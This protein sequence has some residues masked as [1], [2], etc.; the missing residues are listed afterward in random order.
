MKRFCRAFCPKDT[1]DLK[2]IHMKKLHSLAFYALVTPVITLSSGVLFA[3]QPVD[4]D[5]APQQRSS[6]G[7]HSDTRSTSTTTTQSNQTNRPAGHADSQSV[8]DQIEMRDNSRKQNR[9]YMAAVPAN[10]KQVSDLIGAEVSTTGDESVGEVDD[11]IID[12]DGQVVAIVVAVGGFLGMGEKAVAIGWDD[13]TKTG[14]SD[15]LKLR[16]N[17]TREALGSAPEFKKAK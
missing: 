2:E 12:A 8:A 4:E 5:A 3:Q 1:I 15:E 13:V 10:G 9:G 16:V 14:S 11:L 6:Q 17:L 7:A